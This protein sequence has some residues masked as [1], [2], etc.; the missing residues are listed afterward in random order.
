[1][2]Y[3]LTVLNNVHADFDNYS[4]S[5]VDT[6]QGIL[7][8][9]PYGGLSILY[10]KHLSVSGNI[11]HFD[12]SR[13]FGFNINCNNFKYLFVNVYLPYFSEENFAEYTMYI[14]K[15]E[16]I[17]NEY[18]V[19]GLIVMGDFNAE[20]GREYFNQL[21]NFCEDYELI[22]SDVDKLPPDSYT[23]LNNASLR[24]SWLDHCVTSPGIHNAITR[25]TTRIRATVAVNFFP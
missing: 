9:R 18:D 20:P 1:M 25:V 15:L 12:D 3:E 23:H 21:K 19:N 22:V 11:I 24:R 5:A 10:R 6:E 7:V 8:G 17:V 2:P 13:L 16:A 14:G 4:I